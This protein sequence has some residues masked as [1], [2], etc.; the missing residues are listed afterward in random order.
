MGS[1]HMHEHFRRVKKNEKLDLLLN[2]I[3]SNNMIYED[4][5]K[6]ISDF[7]KNEGHLE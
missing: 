7:L 1:N 3:I 2:D 5:I 4:K 6:L